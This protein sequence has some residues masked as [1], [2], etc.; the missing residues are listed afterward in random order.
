MN[1][2]T[3]SDTIGLFWG[4]VAFLTF[5][6]AL[7]RLIRG[8]RHGY[9]IR[10]Q[11]F[12]TLFISSMMSTTLIGWW[13][14]NRIEA[15][16]ALL[17]EE[18]GLSA[19][20]IEQFFVDFGAK[21]GLILGLLTLISAGGAW[22]L[23]WGLASPIE[24][25]A[26]AAEGVSHGRDISS[27]PRPPGREVRRLREA[28]V[29]MHEALEDKRLFEV[30]ITDLSHDL[31]NPVA[32]IKASV[33]VLQAGAAEEKSSREHFIQRVDEASERL[34]T[35]LSDFLS[36][37]RLES[38]GLRF[39]PK[40]F[41]PHLSLQRAVRSQEG[42]AQLKEITL[43][44]QSSPIAIQVLSE[45]GSTIFEGEMSHKNICSVYS[46]LMTIFG[47]HRWLTRAFENLISNAIKFSPVGSTI[48]IDYCVSTSEL[49]ITEMNDVERECI[50]QFC[51][52]LLISDEGSGVPKDLANTL[53]NRFVSQTRTPSSN[54]MGSQHNL[55]QEGTGLGLAIVKQVVEAH[56]GYVKLLSDVIPHQT[57]RLPLN[58]HVSGAQFLITLPLNEV[59]ST[60]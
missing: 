42:V 55:S 57:Q 6:Y 22:A 27:L 46:P 3:T 59:E 51:W 14:L 4:G 33:E 18:N 13:A 31:K 19:E 54:H 60:Q 34:N 5:S 38:R 41:S 9:S 16:A 30:F 48:W 32:A 45:A 36:L 47:S 58:R 23:G 26:A 50:P 37:A 2:V 17:F 44:C 10:L 35:M 56:Q 39:D 8:S 40:P 12:F 28:L 43:V 1:T 21:T 25:L 49:W 53:F 11:L 7:S 24:R 52:Y 20:M 15:R 29:S